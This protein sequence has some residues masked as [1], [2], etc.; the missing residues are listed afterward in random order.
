PRT[1]TVTSAP[2]TWTLLRPLPTTR[3]TLSSSPRSGSP[4]ASSRSATAGVRRKTPS[5]TASCAPARTT[6]GSARPPN[7]SPKATT[8]I[9]LP[10]PVSPVSTVSPGPKPTS[11]CSATARLF[12]RSAINTSS[13]AFKRLQGTRK[14]I[15]RRTEQAS[16]MDLHCSAVQYPYVTRARDDGGAAS[17]QAVLAEEATQMDPVDLRLPRRLGDVPFAP[18]DERREVVALEGI[19]ERLLRLLEG[20]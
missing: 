14:G 8:R 7:R 3:R 16:S 1:P 18:G 11:T 12:I 4:S 9:D 2:L 19:H 5:T 15:P 17:G 13:P 20:T 6:S 10:A